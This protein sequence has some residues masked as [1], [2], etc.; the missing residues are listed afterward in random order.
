MVTALIDL[1][2][3]TTTKLV[4]DVA[5]SDS[6]TQDV[7]LLRATDYLEDWVAVAARA[8]KGQFDS[9]PAW[10]QAPSTPDLPVGLNS[11]SKRELIDLPVIGDSLADK[12]AHYLTRHPQA[13]MND[14]LQIKGIGTT[15]LKALRA[16]SY[17]DHPTFALLSPALL[18]FV[19]AP[20][21]PALVQV[22]DTSDT[23]LEYGDWT[24]YLRRGVPTS[25]P[26]TAARILETIEFAIERAKALPFVSRG[27]LATDALA[28]LDRHKAWAAKRDN[29]VGGTA[30]LVTNASYVAAAQSLIEAA[31]DSLSLMVFLG[32]DAAAK[33]GGVAPEMLIH[34]LEA[35]S[36]TVQVRVIL[37]HHYGG[38]AVCCAG[39]PNPG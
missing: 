19:R 38:A 24:T 23:R 7:L 6:Q 27:V 1:A 18:N 21:V 11:A 37:F 28:R 22:F 39:K 14:L 12:I 36:Q 29:Q 20:S 5:L 16:T 32:T 35:A 31:T 15:G 8:L 10:H 34:A 2:A 13:E 25:S 26:S 17:L 33:P 3:Q 9:D 30:S 4:E